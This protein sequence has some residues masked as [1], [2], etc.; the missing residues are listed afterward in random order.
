MRLPL[1]SRNLQCRATCQSLE[2]LQRLGMNLTAGARFASLAKLAQFMS[3]RNE[4]VLLVC[5]NGHI[6]G[7][8]VGEGC[9]STIFLFLQTKLKCQSF[10]LSRA[11]VRNPRLSVQKQSKSS[12]SYIS[13]QQKGTIPAL[14]H[15]PSTVT[16]MNLQR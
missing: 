4:F 1:D 16:F 10:Q 5:Q 2:N 8:G 15:T 6:R 9:T 11:Q 7:D 12:P 13:I 3:E 14:N